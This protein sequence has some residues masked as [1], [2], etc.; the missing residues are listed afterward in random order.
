MQ[1]KWQE[2]MKRCWKMFRKIRKLRLVVC[3]FLHHIIL[4][5]WWRISEKN[6]QISNLWSMKESQVRFRKTLIVMISWSWEKI[7]WKIRKNSVFPHCMMINCVQCYM[8]NIRFMEEIDFNWKNW[9]MMFLSS[10]REAAEVT[11]CF[12]RVVRKQDLNRK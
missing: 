9:K 4:Q 2:P 1:R 7:W 10:Q 11:K 8:K 12:I 6:I 3:R 5:D